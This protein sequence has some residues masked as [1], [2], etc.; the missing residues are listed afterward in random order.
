MPMGDVT[1]AHHT[2]D[3]PDVAVYAV[4]PQPARLALQSHRYLAP[5]LATRSSQ[6]LLKRLADF[7]GLVR[8]GPSKRARERGS[9]YLWGEARTEDERVVSR[10]QTPDP[11][12]VTVDAA[13][14]ATERVLAGDADTGFQTPAGA[15]GPEFVF[16]LEGVEGVLDEPTSTLTAPS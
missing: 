8:E 11:Y 6:W 1:V 12:A 16:D 4:V 3:V 7:V 5:L 9:A 10:L 2:T 15:F 14:T 13:V